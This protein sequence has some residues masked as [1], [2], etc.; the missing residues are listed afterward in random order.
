M[1]GAE[2]LVKTLLASGVTTCF[3][4]PGTSEM[5]F[6]AALDAHPDMRC[7]L[8]LFEGGATGAA[9]GYFRMTANIAATLLHLAPGFA[10][11][12]ANLHNARK[13]RSAMLTIM[14]DHATHHVQYD[15]P[16]KG[17]TVGISQAISHWTRVCADAVS[18][19]QDGADAV[20][21]A[22]SCG[23]QLATLILPANTAWDVADGPAVAAAPPVL[24]RPTQAAVQ[25]AADVLRHPGAALMVDGLALHTDLGDVASCIA[26]ATGCHLMAPY[27]VSRMRRGAGTVPFQRLRYPVDENVALL[28]DKTALVLCGAARPVSFF[29]YPGKPSL[30]EAAGC[31]VMELCTPE[32]DYAWTLQALAE[33]LGARTP[34]PVQAL[35]VPALPD[36]A[37]TVAKVGQ[38]MAHLMPEDVIVVDEAITS[39]RPL[40]DATMGARAHD[41]LCLMGGAIGDGL[42]VAVGAAVGAP[43]RKVVVWQADGS[44]MYTVQSLWTMAREALDVTVVIFANRGYQILRG[45]LANV[46]MTNVGRNAQRMFDVENPMLDWV[47]LARGHGVPGQRVTDMAGLNAAFAD[48]MANKGPRLIEVVC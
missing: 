45:E 1:N 18:V 7:I 20:R 11:G 47:A 35:A 25:A 16:L 3:A 27:F 37:I 31:H 40:I 12:W 23:G 39:A 38:A 15:S 21:A 29:A 36:G 41:L 43:D 2:A 46:G 13:A 32:M 34:L 26:Q 42:P 17:D 4:N 5:H 9:D 19:A 33:V 10:N 30:P 44:A 14:G 24:R 48:A 8:C 28:A 22:R 6:V